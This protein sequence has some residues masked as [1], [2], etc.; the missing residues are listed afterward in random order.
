MIEKRR[1]QR[2]RVLKGGSIAFEGNNVA[3]T[4]RNISDGGAALDLTNTTGVP[5]SFTLVIA[6]KHLVRRCRPVW[7]TEKRVGVA[8]E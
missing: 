1:S 6:S 2:F 4:V 5:P 3:C 8:F 7:V